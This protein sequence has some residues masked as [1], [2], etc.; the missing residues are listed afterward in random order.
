[1]SAHT[2]TRRHTQQH[3]RNH[4]HA[5]SHAATS[6]AACSGSVLTTLKGSVSV[7]NLLASADT[8]IATLMPS[9]SLICVGRVIWLSVFG[10]GSLILVC[11]GKSVAGKGDKDAR[12]QSWRQQRE[13]SK[14]CKWAPGQTGASCPAHRVQESCATLM[15]GWTCFGLCTNTLWGLGHPPPKP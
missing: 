3:T 15:A 5:H 14:E 12:R 2:H 1:M 10:R 13:Q 9:R 8:L 11:C 7:I 6:V 4:T